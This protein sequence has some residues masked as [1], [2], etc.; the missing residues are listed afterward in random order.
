MAGEVVRR[1]RRSA[2]EG[3]L[4][5]RISGKPTSYNLTH[6]TTAATDDFKMN[7][8]VCECVS[9][10]VCGLVVEWSTRL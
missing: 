2:I 5:G 1:A 10:E 8:L 6:C 4:E 9:L 3:G 7:T